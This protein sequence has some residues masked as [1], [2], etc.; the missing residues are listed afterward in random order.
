M[1]REGKREFTLIELLIVIAI[2]ALLVALLFPALAGARNAAKKVQAK[3]MANNIIIAVKQYKTTYGLMPGWDVDGDGNKD[4]VDLMGTTDV[5][6]DDVLD[7]STNDAK[8]YDILLQILT[9]VD[10]DATASDAPDSSDLANRRKIH[11]INV[12]THYE[13]KG[14]LD[15]WGHRFA[16]LMDRNFNQKIEKSKTGGDIADMN[17]MVAVYSFGPDGIDDDGDSGDHDDIVTWEE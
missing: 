10:M 7:N 17:K 6:W 3:A 13:E 2:I 1:K 4:G 11:F 5:E 9:K 12:P 15:P 8:K 16:V 14:Y